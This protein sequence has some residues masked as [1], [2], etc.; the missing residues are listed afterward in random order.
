LG[1]LFSTY[2]ASAASA[3][4]GSQFKLVLPFTLSDPLG[5]VSVS[6]NLTNALGA[7]APSNATF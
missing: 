7:S 1:T 6:V 3:P 4:F 2:Y 5:V